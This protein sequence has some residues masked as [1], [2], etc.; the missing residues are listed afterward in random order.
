[1][2]PYLT[3]MA[4]LLC[5]NN[6]LWGFQKLD[7]ILNYVPIRINNCQIDKTWHCLHGKCS[8]RRQCVTQR[9]LCQGM[10]CPTRSKHFW[11]L[12]DHK[13]GNLYQGQNRERSFISL[14]LFFY[15]AQSLITILLIVFTRTKQFNRENNR[16]IQQT[17]RSLSNASG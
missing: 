1:M 7:M 15:Q 16:T 14:A 17:M 9:I 11:M 3:R 5:G 12:L 2:P 6:R 4:L 8:I 13:T 10:A